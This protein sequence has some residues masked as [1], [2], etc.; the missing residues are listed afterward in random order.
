MYLKLGSQLLCVN[1][2][3]ARRNDV[4]G[5]E[6]KS[7]LAYS[8]AIT[9]AERRVTYIVNPPLPTWTLH[10]PNLHVLLFVAS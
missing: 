8:L 10:V 5:I 7:V 6:L 4:T 3:V 2:D 9:P 1:V